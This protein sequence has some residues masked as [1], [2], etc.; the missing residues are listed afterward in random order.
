MRDA[1]NDENVFSF[2]LTTM[3]CILTKECYGFSVYENLFIKAYHRI[4]GFENQIKA[5]CPWSGQLSFV[6]LALMCSKKTGNKTLIGHS[7]VKTHQSGHSRA[8]LY[9]LGCV[10]HL[11]CNKQQRTKTGQL[12]KYTSSNIVE[13]RSVT[14]LNFLFY[15]SAF[16]WQYF[17]RTWWNTLT[18]QILHESVLGSPRYDRM[19]ATYLA[20]GFSPIEYS[21]NWPGS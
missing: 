11:I 6:A 13:Y 21:V 12:Y 5:L 20:P 14:S 19:N 9:S 16:S 8:S 3:M 4:R 18:H 2:S 15:I 7:F 10:F 17:S 1:I